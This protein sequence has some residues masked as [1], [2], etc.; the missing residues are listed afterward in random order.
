[1]LWPGFPQWWVT[2]NR[3]IQSKHNLL[4]LTALH[5]DGLK[6]KFQ[7]DKFTIYTTFTTVPANK[8]TAYKAEHNYTSAICQMHLPVAEEGTR[9]KV[10][11]KVSNKVKNTFLT[12]YMKRNCLLLS[13]FV[14]MMLHVCV[15]FRQRWQ[16]I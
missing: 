5:R 14:L 9:K 3:F 6:F 7:E 12:V 4:R 1:M 16:L 11:W 13:P 8:V 15:C 2:I 10:I